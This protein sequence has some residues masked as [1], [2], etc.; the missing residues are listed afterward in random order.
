MVFFTVLRQLAEENSSWLPP[1]CIQAQSSF[2]LSSFLFFLSSPTPSLHST[3]SILYAECHCLVPFLFN[4]LYYSSLYRPIF[5]TT[6]F[7]L[8][9]INLIFFLSVRNY[10]SFAIAFLPLFL[11]CFLFLPSVRPS[12]HPSFLPSFL[13]PFRNSYFI[14]FFLLS[15]DFC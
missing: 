3:P 6:P 8:L 2:L 12:I 10:S 13:F 11:I 4:H 5:K 9:S 15:V 1:S 14:F 7:F